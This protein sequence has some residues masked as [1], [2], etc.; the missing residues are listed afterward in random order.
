[1]PVTAFAPASTGNVSLGFDILGLSLAPVDGTALG[2]R[3][4]VVAEQ[5]EF[6]LTCSGR[7]ADKLP[8]EAQQNIVY[9]CFLGFQ[10]AMQGLGIDVAPV[11]MKLEKNLPIGSGL[12]SSAAS[13]V[14]ALA[15]LNAFYGYPLNQE[16]L[17]RLM[18][19]LEGQ[20]SGSIHYDNVAPSYLG[21]LQLMV[22]SETQVSVSLPVF[23]NWYWVVCYS[24]AS[25]ST[26]AARKILPAEYSRANTIEF[27]RQL[28]VFT[29]ALYAKDEALAASVM[30]DV[31]AEPY[32]KSLLEGFDDA[33][34]FAEQNGALAFGISGSGPTVFAA[35]KDLNNA[36][37]IK[38][39][40]ESNYIKNENGFAHVCRVD[41]HGTQISEES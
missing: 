1:M 40:L 21:G 34:E 26:S 23:D 12:G 22:E 5:S 38:Q 29:H 11:S 25:V 4:T 9:D 16:R 19:E 41:Q 2:D 14:A 31:I 13:I 18:G 35:V 7:F 33:R 27:G 36:E 20:I 3:V 15:A 28:A 39:W 6:S 10:K 8:A 30:R 17:L 24:G 32:R 37:T